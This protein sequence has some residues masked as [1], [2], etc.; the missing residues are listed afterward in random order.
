MEKLSP[1][2]PLTRSAVIPAPADPDALVRKRFSYYAVLD[3]KTTCLDEVHTFDALNQARSP[4]A[5]A[6]N[7]GPGLSGS[8]NADPVL[9]DLG[10]LRALALRFGLRTLDDVALGAADGSYVVALD[11]YLAATK[12]GHFVDLAVGP[13]YAT[14]A[15]PDGRVVAFSACGSPCGGHY[16]VHLLDTRT[17]KVQ[18]ADTEDVASDLGI[19]WSSTGDTV[20]YPYAEGI[21]PTGKEHKRCVGGLDTKTL[22]NKK[23]ACVEGDG[24]FAASPGL[25]T[26]VLGSERRDSHRTALWVFRLDATPVLSA[27]P[28]FRANGSAVYPIVEDSGRLLWEDNDGEGFHFRVHIAT[29]Q[30]SEVVDDARLVGPLPDG[31]VLVWPDGHPSDWLPPVATLENGG[32]CGMM[33]R[34]PPK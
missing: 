22:R 15:S 20:L 26:F 34:R 4:D 13:A 33:Q 18:R 7:K 6:S 5:V 10:R 17:G 19:R 32:R 31:S 16:R 9:A 8:L 28:A 25:A 24:T 1:M 12:D 14:T 23:V 3:P 30:G 2:E 11:P 21:G 27:T 29:A